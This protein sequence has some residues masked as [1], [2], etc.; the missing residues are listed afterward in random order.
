MTVTS[1]RKEPMSTLTEQRHL[2]DLEQRI[3]AGDT[4]ITPTQLAEARQAAEHAALVAEARR[5]ASDQAEADQLE[6]QR[7]RW[8]TTTNKT[9]TDAL[10]IGQAAYSTA[11]NAFAELVRAVQHYNDT[12]AAARIEAAKVGLTDEAPEAITIAD[13]TGAALDEAK[14]QPTLNRRT[15]VRRDGG[16]WT[17]IPATLKRHLFHSDD[18]VAKV[19]QALTEDAQRQA[20]RSRANE[21]QRHAERAVASPTHHRRR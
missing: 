16:Q 5:R 6:R 3:L 18:H 17:A 14:G 20:E 2:T 4:T 19:N 9:R 7:Q 8:R 21:Q 13:I 11:V 12:V 1:H 15:V 10:T